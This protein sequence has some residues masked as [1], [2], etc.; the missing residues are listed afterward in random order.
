MISRT[1]TGVANSNIIQDSVL[2]ADKQI[3]RLSIELF[4]YGLVKYAY[5]RVGNILNNIDIS[6]T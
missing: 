1:F 5:P 6:D 4:Q 2:R 3:T